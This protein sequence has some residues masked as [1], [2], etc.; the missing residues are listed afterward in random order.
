MADTLPP[1][2]AVYRTKGEDRMTASDSPN[3]VRRLTAR[4]SD[5]VP[6]LPIGEEEKAPVPAH[7]RD[8]GDECNC[9]SCGS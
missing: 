7:H 4:E 1:A 3:I 5:Q 2:Q 8:R 6:S 9:P